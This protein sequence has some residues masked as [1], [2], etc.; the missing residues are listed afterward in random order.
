[1]DKYNREYRYD[2][3]CDCAEQICADAFTYSGLPY[4]FDEDQAMYFNIGV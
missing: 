3:E 2:Y 1:M 4:V